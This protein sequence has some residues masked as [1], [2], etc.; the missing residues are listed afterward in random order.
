MRFLIILTALALLCLS[1]PTT[2]LGINRLK[3]KFLTQ[4]QKAQSCPSS[5][6]LL[7]STPRYTSISHDKT[8]TDAIDLAIYLYET[9]PTTAR[10]LG[11]PFTYHDYFHTS[12]WRN[13]TIDAAVKRDLRWALNTQ[14]STYDFREEALEWDMRDLYTLQSS[15][16]FAGY[17]YDRGLMPVV[18]VWR[19]V[20]A[21]KWNEDMYPRVYRDAFILD[22]PK[23]G[24]GVSM[25]HLA[26][27]LL[28]IC[29]E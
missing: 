11:I 10:T 17:D 16:I 5:T 19:G 9:Q 4:I 12:R 18:N 24:D 6:K 23:W 7:L 20:G 26:I 29:S 15:L 2:T 8:I 1:F 25:I 28:G 27:G 21:L 13:V 22:S 3:R 14:F